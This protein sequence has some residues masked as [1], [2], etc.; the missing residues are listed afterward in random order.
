[1]P[2][3][4]GTA[5]RWNMTLM[6]I[7]RSMMSYSDLPD[8]SWGYALETAAYII[9][10]VPSKSVPYIPIELWTG[11]KPSLKHVRIWG[12]SAHILK[13]KAEK[14]ESRIEVCLFIGYPRGTKGDLFY[15]FKD[16]TVV[17]STKTR[18]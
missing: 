16:Q 5:E 10:L 2:Q 14:L 4:N 17:V 12:I 7:V 1:M 18:F 9:N 8:F 13:G 15:S 11:H 3:Q 6:E